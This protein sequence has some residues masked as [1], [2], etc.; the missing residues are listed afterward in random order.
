M[1]N[2]CTKITVEARTVFGD[3][4]SRRLR[5]QGMIPAIIYG[6][7][8]APR[9][10]TVNADEWS[11]FSAGHNTHMVTLVEGAVETPALVREVQFNYL[12]N[13]FIHIDFQEIDLDSEIS[14]TVAI[15]GIGDCPGAAHGGVL[16][17][18][19]HE[20]PVVCR[21]AD[22][23]EVIKVDLSKLEVGEVISVADLNMP[24]GVRADV[25]AEAIVFHV[26]QPNEGNGAAAE[27]EEG[28]NEPEA[29]NEK[30]A[31]SRAAEKE[32]KGK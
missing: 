3:N 28:S 20:L 25:E 27:G 11:A 5:R 1:S 22:L 23:P 12:K 31:A 32:A 29:I 8:K 15:H 13:Y 6:N 16:E 7:G 18:E 21:P 30:K 10:L 17:Q 26:V 19:I 24:A 2:E 14:S 4:A 9:A